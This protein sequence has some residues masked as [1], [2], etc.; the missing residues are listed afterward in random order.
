MK[1][2]FHLDNSIPFIKIA[3]FFHLD[4]QVTFIKMNYNKHTD[5]YG[6]NAA[7]TG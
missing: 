3:V 5:K 1:F 7:K 6:K 4:K 2:S